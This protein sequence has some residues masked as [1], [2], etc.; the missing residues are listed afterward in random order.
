MKTPLFSKL[1]S[2]ACEYCAHGHDTKN[3]DMVQC[4]V[5]GVVSPYYRCKRFVYNPI[6]R[7]PHKSEALPKANPEDFAL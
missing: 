4:T 2:P 1:I 5:K 7:K 3:G 6:R